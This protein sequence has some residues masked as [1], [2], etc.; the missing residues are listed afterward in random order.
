MRTLPPFTQ[1]FPWWGGDLQTLATALIDAP[2]SLAPATSERLSIKLADGDTML[3]MLDRPPPPHAKKPL[4]L[5]IHGVPGSEA[6]P[7]LRRMSGYL[8]AQGYPVLRLNMRGAGPSRATCGGQYSAASSRDLAELIARLPQDLTAAGL[9]AV[10]YSVGGAILL[11]YLGEAGATAPLLAAASVSAPIDL[12]GTCRSLLR[13]RNW[14]YHRHVFE[15]VRSEALA[16]G[17]VLTDDERRAITG[18]R[19][20]YEFDDVFTAPR[21]GFKGAEDYYLHASALNFLPAI[22]VPTLVLAALDDPWVPGGA[23]A[24]HYWGHHWEGANRSGSLTPVLTRHG[25]HVGFHG[26]GGYRPWSDLAVLTF[27]EERAA[28]S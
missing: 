17:A 23:Y 4:V 6:S 16:P 2:S 9:A 18:A 27:L 5:L 20:L 28:A 7:Y 15:A 11:K 22:A 14:L 19:T 1:R 10:G 21:N 24:G 12:L 13:L 26:T 25:G 8:L 3:A